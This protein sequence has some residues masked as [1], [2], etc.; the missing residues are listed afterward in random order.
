MMQTAAEVYK[1]ETIGVVLTGMGRDGANGLKA[2]KQ[3]G[4]L[5]IAQDEKTSTIFGMPKVAIDEGYVD[6]ILSLSRI[7]NEM[8]QACQ[9]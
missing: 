5:T 3:K 9:T 8:M 6:K 7:P 1:S 4:G 2:I